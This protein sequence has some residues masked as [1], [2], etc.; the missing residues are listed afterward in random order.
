MEA[1]KIASFKRIPCFLLRRLACLTSCIPPDDTRAGKFLKK[2]EKSQRCP[3]P[4]SI[5]GLKPFF[6]NR[7]VAT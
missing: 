5:V 6:L 7:R 2:P 4:K 1:M 3:T